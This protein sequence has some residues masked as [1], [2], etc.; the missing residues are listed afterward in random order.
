MSDTLIP[1]VNAVTPSKGSTDSTSRKKYRAC[2]DPHRPTCREF[3]N[4]GKC[5]RRRHCKFYHPKVIT[6]EITK[7]TK[8]N[9]G[10]C[11]CGAHQRT[12][13]VFRGNRDIV[14]PTFFR[15]CDRTG[16]SMRKCM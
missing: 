8:R 12:I 16:K 13:M 9:L 10:H 6:Q 7:Q 15:V 11:Y 4:Q 5:H 2:N 3:V 1:D 14:T